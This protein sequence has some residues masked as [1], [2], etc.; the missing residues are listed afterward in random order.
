M[1]D[2]KSKNLHEHRCVI[3]FCIKL[4]KMV[5]ETKERIDEVYNESVKS[6]ASV[7]HGYN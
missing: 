6:H 1:S 7:Y 2:E 3:T 5:K 4:K